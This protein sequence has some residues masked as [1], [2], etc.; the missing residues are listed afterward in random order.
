MLR[1]TEEEEK[2]GLT[3]AHISVEHT[4]Q[5]RDVTGVDLVLWFDT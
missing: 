4:V 1:W 5:S 2:K 3:V